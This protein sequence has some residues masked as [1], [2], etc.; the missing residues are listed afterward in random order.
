VAGLSDAGRNVEPAVELS[1]PF[2]ERHDVSTP[3]MTSTESTT[4]TP[5]TPLPSLLNEHELSAVPAV[6]ASAQHPLPLM[7]PASREPFVKM[8]DAAI[9]CGL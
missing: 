6:R 4:P 2:V 1:A 9:E 8:V 3:L 7:S 5:K